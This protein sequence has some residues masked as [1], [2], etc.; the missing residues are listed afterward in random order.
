MLE[1]ATGGLGVFL[2]K[3][4]K[5]KILVGEMQG[6]RSTF[7]VSLPVALRNQSQGRQ[8]NLLGRR[9]ANMSLRVSQ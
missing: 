5:A 9:R 3:K 8:S 6:S 7:E 4:N 1:W 2:E